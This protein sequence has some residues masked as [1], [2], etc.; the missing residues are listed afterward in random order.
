MEDAQVLLSGKGYHFKGK[1]PLSLE[2]GSNILSRYYTVRGRG[3][4]CLH[5]VSCAIEVLAAGELQG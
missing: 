1:T 4:R 3:T 5:R 2:N